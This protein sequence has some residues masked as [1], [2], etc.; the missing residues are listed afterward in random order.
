MTAAIERPDL[1]PVQNI[2]FYDEPPVKP[3]PLLAVG[4]LAWARKN[5]FAT[6]VDTIL[7]LVTTAALISGII[8]FL[9]WA[10]GSA[11]WLVII[12]NF[13]ILMLG[14]FPPDAAWRVN[15]VALIIMVIVGFTLRSYGRVT[16]PA[17]VVL[18]AVLALLVAAPPVIRLT[19]TQAT[20][21]VAAGV[22]EVESGTVTEVPQ[23]FVGFVGAAG[24]VVRVAVEPLTAIDDNA[25]ASRS[26]FL[27]RSVQG[28]TNAAENRLEDIEMRAQIEA[29]LA[30]TLLTDAQRADL[31]EQLADLTIPAAVSVTYATNTAPVT[32]RILN[33][34]DPALPV[35]AEAELVPV[36]L[37]LS[38][39][40]PPVTP[41]L[42][43]TLPADGWY[44]LSKETTDENAVAILD[45]TG[46]YPLAERDLGGGGI[47]YS[48]VTDDFETAAARP[49][50]DE[51][52]VPALLLND[53][54]YQGTR[55]LN[56]YL[57]LAVAPLFD[58]LA[59]G[60]IPMALAGVL[61]YAAAS[62]LMRRAA[63]TRGRTDNAAAARSLVAPLW[64][65][66]LIALFLLPYGIPALTPLEL[67]VVLARFVWV[68]L[69]FFAGAALGQAWG[70]P[71]LALAVVLGLAQSIIAERVID[72]IEI[73]RVLG[74]VMWMLI[75]LYAARQGSAR[76]GSLNGRQI[77]LGAGISFGVWIIL[78]VLPPLLI[79]G[80]DV[81]P[82]I[83]TRRWGGLM[84][85]MM[86]TVVAILA[87]F[88]LGVLLA[89]G[90]RSS[91]PVVKWSCTIYIEL[92]R[93]VPLITVLFMAQLL[94]PLVNVSLA[95]V[96]NVLRAMVGLTLFS[97]AYLAENVRGGL[98]SIPPGQE[99]AAR[100]LGLAS[101]QVTLLITLPQ[102][103]RAVIPALVG[104]CIALF[105][106][107]SLVA[108][109][110]LSDLTK[111]AQ[112]VIAQTE[113]VGLQTEVYVFI[114]VLY[115]V[116]SYMMAYISRRIE[117]SGSGAARRV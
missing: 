24:D 93:G 104:Q 114:S 31:T 17:L 65:L 91:L 94:V 71:L 117:A 46:I 23:P 43:F 90:R 22:R 44:V 63:R 11:N 89:L 85:T 56:D 108:L 66:G 29:R 59:R 61:G 69:M 107:T 26:G 10:V 4:A 30:G 60:L 57:R 14:S 80:T 99:E 58:L 20:T 62:G 33:G 53:T 40:E 87:S 39:P 55:S 113:F 100:A 41:E 75:G 98:Q 76:R 83:D 82:V 86:L 37:T 8:G 9:T 27:D 38:L 51:R 110:G 73:G 84:L 13:R 78:L 52:D 115:F 92:V 5:L 70:R 18:L 12:R 97:G 1:P 112:N 36:D 79:T 2:A 68:G 47:T 3:P 45:L 50:I 54:Q 111:M 101:W 74:V 64:A 88:P 7:T 96:D 25:L 81:L 6:P 102:A 72:Q 16:R 28:I 48:R 35:L 19:T 42:V 77:A 105:K 109:V 21:Y 95:D 34:A 32:V 106:D 15:I 103:L 67:G 116:F 49:Q